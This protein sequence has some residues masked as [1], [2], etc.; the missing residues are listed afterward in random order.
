MLYMLKIK[1]EK[2]TKFVSF[3]WHF[4]SSNKAE[5][6]ADFIRNHE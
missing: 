4:L 2:K 5:T 6:S 1:Y 3:V